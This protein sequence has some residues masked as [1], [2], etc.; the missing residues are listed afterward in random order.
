MSASLHELLQPQVILDVV[1]RI[2]ERQ[3]RL[4]KWLGFQPNKF[5]PMTVALSGPNTVPGD[6]RYATFRL[7]DFTRV[8]AKA[9]APATG[10][11]TVAAN[12]VGDVRISC[13][14]FHMKI[15]LMYEEL[16][17]LS[18][19]MGPNSQ[20]DTGGQ[21]Y[22]QRQERFIATQFNNAVELMSTGMLQDSLWFVQSGD[23]WL[24][25]LSDPGTGVRFQVPFQVP[26][27]NKA[28]LNMLGT[29]D[30]LSVSWNNPAAPIYGNISSIKMATA[31]LTGYP[32]TDVWVN[33][34]SWYEVITNT[35]IRNL[36]GSSQTPFAEFDNVAEKGMDGEETGAYEAILRADPTITWHVTDEVLVTGS[37]IDP[38][39]STGSGTIVKMVPD[40]LAFFLPK[41]SSTWTRMYHGGEY[42]VENPGMAGVLR[43]GYYFWRE[44][45]T[46][47]SAVE[48]IGLLN[49]IPLLYIPKIVVAGTI[50]Y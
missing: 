39:Y 19:I 12:P 38:S 3:G 41:P 18:P 5:D 4:G 9:R 50:I 7:F 37:D 33:S 45:V 11:A 10:P 49:A 42:V 43:R 6:T 29:G 46:Q 28:K 2:R 40:N 22:L 44:Y 36:A 8:I 32:L 25:Q 48:L 21:D 30:I 31:Q 20:V 34:G 13:A 23:N 15:P 24:P 1:S 16:G 35:E 47:P 14:R 17:N 27:G 26:S